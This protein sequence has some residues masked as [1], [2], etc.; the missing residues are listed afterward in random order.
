MVHEVKL[1]AHGCRE[2]LHYTAVEFVWDKKLGRRGH[3]QAEFEG[4]R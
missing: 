4:S 3:L 1:C 2:G